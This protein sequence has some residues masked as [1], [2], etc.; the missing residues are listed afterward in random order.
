MCA[1]TTWR[2]PPAKLALGSDE[3]HVWQASLDV[4]AVLHARWQTTLSADELVRAQRFHSSIH[5]DRYI[6]GRG[7]LRDL[8]ARYLR[9]PA[10]GFQFSLNAHGKPALAPGS[11]VADVRFNL[12]HSGDLALFAF[13]MSR[14]VGV[15][16][17]CLRPLDR[18]MDLAERFFSPNEVEEI[19]TLPVEFQHQL[20]FQCWT[21]KEAYIKARGLG[22]SISLSSFSVPIDSH[23]NAYLPIVDHGDTEARRWR[24][25]ALK[26]SDGY[27]AAVAT[28][29]TDWSLDLWQFQ[30]EDL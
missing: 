1:E 4:Q 20:F 10:R 2:M 16:V 25:R 11:E 28:E 24:L 22:L 14:D 21:R 7:I 5:R 19:R 30:S 13:T 3:V 18:A 29:G 27:V 12:S 26:P 6:A 17:E 23:L 15:D 8:L 9:T